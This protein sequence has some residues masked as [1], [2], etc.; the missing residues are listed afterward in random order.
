MKEYSNKDLELIRKLSQLMSEEKILNLKYE[1][2]GLKL[3]ID[4]SCKNE[5]LT[6]FQFNPMSSH[7]NCILNPILVPKP[8]QNQ[9]K[10]RK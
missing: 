7:L 8:T 6:K 5:N 3:S 1:K 9:P 10:C 2:S 4:K